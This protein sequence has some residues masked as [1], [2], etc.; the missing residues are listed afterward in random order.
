MLNSDKVLSQQSANVPNAVDD[1][2][3]LMQTDKKYMF[4][5]QCLARQISCPF[6][7]FCGLLRGVQCEVLC[8][9]LFLFGVLRRPDTLC[10]CV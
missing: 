8:C 5:G 4:I 7:L 3:C 1:A 6:S 2:S 10:H 9:G